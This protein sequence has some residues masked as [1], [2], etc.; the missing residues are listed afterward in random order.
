MQKFQCR[1]QNLHEL[2][3]SGKDTGPRNSLNIS[4]A[5]LQLSVVDEALCSGKQQIRLRDLLVEGITLSKVNS[6][7]NGYIPDV[8]IKMSSS[9]AMNVATGTVLRVSDSTTSP[10]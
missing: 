9:P 3:C 10:C 2:A 8:S 6:Q 7:A 4:Y 1:V 5:P